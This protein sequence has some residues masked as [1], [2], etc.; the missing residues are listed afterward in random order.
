MLKTKVQKA[1]NDQMNFEIYS[2]Y[3]YAAMSAYA[4]EKNFPGFANWLRIQAG[5]EL[6]IHAAKFEK[7]IIDRGGHVDFDKIDKPKAGWDSLLAVFENAYRHECKVSANINALYDVAVAEDDK[8]AQQFLAWFI[9]E[10]VEE[11]KNTDQIVQQLKI[12]AENPQG[13]FML[14]QQ[15]SARTFVP[16]PTM[17]AAG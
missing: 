14:D 15:L 6:L 12:I 17:S 11:E 1:L 16:D 8:A 7:F 9:N 5:E 3:I 4:A 10:Q 13:L 2:A